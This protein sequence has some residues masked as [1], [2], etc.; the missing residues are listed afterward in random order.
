MRNVEAELYEP[1]IDLDF[2]GIKIDPQITGAGEDDA[3]RISRNALGKIKEFLEQNPVTDDYSLRFAARSGGCSGMVYKLGLDNQ[4]IEGDRKH[5]I[6]GVNIVFDPKSVY[7]LM[8]VTLD[9][10]DDMNGSG[11]IFNNPNNE[12]TCGC[13]H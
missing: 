7:Y 12:N 8:G 6:E 13:S 3:I 2:D 10:I 9:Y 4:A 1:Q 5:N 11:F